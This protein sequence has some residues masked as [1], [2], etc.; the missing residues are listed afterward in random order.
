MRIANV[1]AVGPSRAG[2]VPGVRVDWAAA[3]H[4]LESLHAC[5]RSRVTLCHRGA[6]RAGYG[7]TGVQNCIEDEDALD[8]L[9]YPSL[10]VIRIENGHTSDDCALNTGG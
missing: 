9:L 4:M 8:A 2:S 1:H 5:M 6:V 3:L 10:R 7:A